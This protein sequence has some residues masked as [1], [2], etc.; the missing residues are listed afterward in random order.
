[1]DEIKLAVGVLLVETAVAL[2]SCI[3]RNTTLNCGDAFQDSS[4][5]WGRLG[6][7][8]LDDQPLIRVS[9]TNVLPVHV[10][11]DD[12]NHKDNLWS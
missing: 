9:I 3:A 5:V 7:G 1:M 8:C 6:I 11:P 4:V 12:Q 2:K 10:D